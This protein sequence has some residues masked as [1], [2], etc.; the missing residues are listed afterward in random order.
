MPRFKRAVTSDQSVQD[1]IA[2]VATT[3]PEISTR[4]RR[5]VNAALDDMEWILKYGTPPQRISLTRTLVPV[6]MRAMTAAQAEGGESR[7]AFDRMMAE[8]RGDVGD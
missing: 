3:D 2:E 4:V 8:L 7:E 5:L 1:A 6:M